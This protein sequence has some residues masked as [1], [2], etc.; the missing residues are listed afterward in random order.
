MYSNL[1]YKKASPSI[2]SCLITVRAAARRALRE[3][4][5]FQ[6]YLNQFLVSEQLIG[7]EG[8]FFREEYIRNILASAVRDVP[9]YNELGISLESIRKDP[10]SALM[11]FP[12]QNKATIREAGDRLVSSR[13]AKPLF[14]GSTSGTTGSPLF[15]W[16]DLA[17]INRENAAAWRQLL[18]AGFEPGKRRAW[19]RGD[20]IVPVTVDKPPFW[21]MNY[22]ENMEMFSSYHLS[23]RNA[24]A[25]IQELERFDPQ[26]IQAYPSSVA[27]LAEWLNSNGNGYQGRELKGIVTSSESLSTDQQE[28]I[29]RAFG[30][31]VFDWYGQFE[32]VAAI[33]TCEHGRRHIIS[34]Y[35]H[36]ELAPV[37]GGLFEII[38]T[39][40]NNKA[41]PLIRYRTGDFV[42]LSNQASCPCGREFPIVERILGRQ[43]D[44]VLLPNGR[45]IGRMDHIFKGANHILEAQIVQDRIDQIVVNVVL[46]EGA[47]GV[48]ELLV[49]NARE[50]LGTEVDVQVKRVSMIERTRNGK[51][52]N[53]ICNVG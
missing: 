7:D 15:L 51:L 42:T 8:K 24:P 53:V 16:Q 45:K 5:Q 48:E 22:A 52:R 30:V 36:V 26:I 25:Y 43:D 14:R 29:E 3:R 23:E 44:Y 41:M 20:L 1:I 34:D 17:A 12:L 27:F 4:K 28:S 40:F 11:Q 47:H 31:R 32:R 33:G 13:A 21:R 18:W 9:I 46:G 39:G 50:R 2:Q 38:G 49:A 6:E 35:S 37:D 19:I 10:I